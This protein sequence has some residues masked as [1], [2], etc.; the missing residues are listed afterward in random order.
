MATEDHDFEEINHFKVGDKKF[1][2]ETDQKGAVGR[3]KIGELKQVFDEFSNW[4]PEL[5]N[6]ANELR[7]LFE[8]AYLKHSNLAAA[9]RY[10]VHQLFKDSGV[11]IVDGDDKKLKTLFLHD[12]H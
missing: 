6:N 1:T 5:S 9:T 11:I 3:M 2:W 8:N 7:Q 4:L 10:L 12:L